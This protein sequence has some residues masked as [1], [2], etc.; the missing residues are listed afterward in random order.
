MWLFPMPILQLLGW[1]LGGGQVRP[2]DTEGIRSLVQVPSLEK[3]NFWLQGWYPLCH[4][5]QLPQASGE[6]SASLSCSPGFKAAYPPRGQDWPH[7]SGASLGPHQDC[8]GHGVHAL[9]SFPSGL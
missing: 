9:H 7:K 2:Q 1:T 5:H 6:E 3:R 4:Q 8:P